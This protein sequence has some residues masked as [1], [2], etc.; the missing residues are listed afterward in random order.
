NHDFNNWV[1]WVSFQLKCRQIFG[2]SYLPDFGY[3]RGGRGWRDLWQ[4]LLSIFLVDPESARQEIINNFGGIR[5]DGSNATIIGTRP[6][7]FIADRNNVPRTWCDHAAWPVFVLNFYIQQSGDYEILFKELPYW[8]DQFSHRCKKIDKN[9][10]E[11]YGFQQKT[12]SGEVYPGS[13]FEHVLLQ[14]LAAFFHV[15]EHNNLLLEGADWN[16]TLDMARERGESV[17]FYNFYGANLNILA[18]L[19]EH[20]RETGLTQ[21]SLLTEVAMLLDT[22][23]NQHNIDYGSP[24]E[25]QAVLQKYFDSVSHSVSGGKT[26]IPLDELIDDLRMKADH[27]L[28][29]IRDNEWISTKEGY[30]F[31]NGHYDNDARRVH[32]DH[33]LGVRMDLTSQVMPV[34]FDVATDEQIGEI[35]RSAKQYLKDHDRP[36][37]RLCTDFRELKLNLGRITGFVYGY[38]EHGSKW[39]QQNVML[40]YGLYKRGFVREGYEIFRD[41]FQLCIDSATAKIFPGIP[42]YLE[43]G[44]RGAYAYL[45]GS[46]TWLILALTTQMFGVRGEKG[47]LCLEPKLM[48]EQFSE[49]GETEIQCAFRNIGLRIHFIKRN[50]MDWPDY[51]ISGIT[52]NGRQAQFDKSQNLNKAVIDFNILEELCT[53]PINHIEVV[54]SG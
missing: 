24:R 42:S 40:M 53:E 8:K 51:L 38:K 47:N 22:P 31:F 41:V 1:R 37:L 20:L 34:M 44:D 3:G 45:T 32:G 17:C 29:H 16:D 33:E 23:G 15:G 7:E 52:V 11:K 25:K 39:M 18:D 14:Q 27:I 6:G 36:G 49:N 43:P 48:A 10:S 5:V 50:K 13:I 30:S 28:N 2:N 35:V 19:L 46:S 26:D 12:E 9:W 54:L 21:I 4:D